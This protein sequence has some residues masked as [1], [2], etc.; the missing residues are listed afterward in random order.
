MPFKKQ[1]EKLCLAENKPTASFSSFQES[2]KI[3]VGSY[4][5]GA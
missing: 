1:Q 4:W 3:L 2:G 5:N